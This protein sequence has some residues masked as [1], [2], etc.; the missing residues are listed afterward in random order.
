MKRI[1][2]APHNY[3]AGKSCNK[4]LND[5]RAPGGFCEGKN[6]QPYPIPVDSAEVGFWG[7]PQNPWEFMECNPGDCQGGPTH[8]CFAGHVGRKCRM[9]DDGWFSIS[10]A[11]W[12]ECP[13]G[14]DPRQR[15][16]GGGQNMAFP[17][18]RLWE[19]SPLHSVTS[20]QNHHNPAK[21]IRT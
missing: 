10:D 14:D 11:W 5:T 6:T 8:A 7:D 18:Y 4:S 12:I 19:H 13:G 2:T 21:F 9:L 17:F 15:W 16:S 20:H 1:S 3:T